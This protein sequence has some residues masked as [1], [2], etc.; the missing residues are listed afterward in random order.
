MKIMARSLRFGIQ[1]VA[2][3]VA[4][5]ITAAVYTQTAA[6][7]FAYDDFMQI[8]HNPGI[9]SW[10]LT[11]KY[12]SSQVWAQVGGLSYYYRPAFM[13]WLRA[14][15]ALFGRDAMLWHLSAIALHLLSCLLLYFFIKRLTGDRW[16][17]TLAML[18]FGLHP[19]HVEA[20]AWISG[21][22][23]TMM[24]VLLLGSL[25]CYQK[26]LDSNGSKPGWQ[27][28]SLLLA[29]FAVF[30]KETA[31]VL[32]A[33]IFSYDWIFHR[34]D[35]QWQTRLSNATRAAIPYAVISVGFLA[36]RKFALGRVT[37]PRTAD[38]LLSVLLAWPQ[39]IFFY[40]AHA[41]LPVRMSAFYKLLIVT[42]PGLWNFFVPFLLLVVAAAFLVY[43][44]R[45]SPV[46]MFFAIWC[47]VLLVPL[48]VLT[49]SYNLENVHDRYLYLPTAAVCVLL[50]ALVSRLKESG[51]IKAAL[52]ALIVIGS[53]YA[54]ITIQE[55]QYWE[56]DTTLGQ[57]AL[58]VSP[59]N[60]L[61]SQLL[62]N[63]YIRD[64]R[65]NEAIPFLL[66]SLE[67]QPGNADT[68]RSLGE[69]Y[70]LI[71][72][73]PLAEQ[74][75]AK[76]MARNSSRPETYLYLGNLRLRQNR[77]AEAEEEIRRGIALQR[78]STGVIMYHYYLGNVLDAK[79]DLQGAIREY[80]LEAR[81]DS[82]IDPTAITALTRLHQIEQRQAVQAQ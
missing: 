19:A 26:Q 32:P 75:L 52:G 2:V 39:V 16:I 43:G 58:E 7:D 21:A 13:F 35:G 1:R 61:A 22:T 33:L 74:Y 14:N 81:N 70:L 3:I 72:A 40:T 63:A 66:D 76:S 8:V 55:S 62:G 69:C 65:V 67:A 37:P 31:V 20:V 28:A 68:L 42:Q 30:T 5:L 57:H 47:S 11:L 41:F 17:S 24:A 73:L 80:Q 49:L 6:F 59:G 51:R 25:L 78:A 34:L 12:F 77:L 64:E 4:L 23:E 10:P 48:L 45:R 60:A 29:A 53:V 18:L 46:F 82:R 38:S 15:Y 27:A 56:N 79:G 50:A 54:A 71:N 36:L 9:Q 44:S